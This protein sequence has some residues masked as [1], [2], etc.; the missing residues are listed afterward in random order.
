MMHA[1]NYQMKYV[2][3]YAG[4]NQTYDEAVA[5]CSALNATLPVIEAHEDN[6]FLFGRG[7][8][9][10]DGNFCIQNHLVLAEMFGKNPVWLGLRQVPSNETTWS[11]SWPDGTRVDYDNWAKNNPTNSTPSKECVKLWPDYVGW[12]KERDLRDMLETDK[13]LWTNEYCACPGC[14]AGVVCRQPMT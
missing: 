10:V 2:M 7:S 5:T 14:V 4:C 12:P 11:G 8:L 3:K 13:G 1:E 9:L 6:V